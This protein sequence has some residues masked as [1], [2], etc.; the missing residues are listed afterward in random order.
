[1]C[2]SEKQKAQRTRALAAMVQENRVLHIIQLGQQ[3]ER[4]EQIYAESILPRLE[5]NLYRPRV[6]SIK[7][8]DIQI[9]RRLL[10]LA[11]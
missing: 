8:A 11:L 3:W 2:L 6:L 4:D 1:M 9:R 7:K 10:G 5:T